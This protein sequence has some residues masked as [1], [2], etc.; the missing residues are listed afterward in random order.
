M[1]HRLNPWGG[2]CHGT[3]Q[4]RLQASKEGG[5]GFLQVVFL[6]EPGELFDVAGDKKAWDHVLFVRP[7]TDNAVRA[8]G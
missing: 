7:F 1:L 8:L 2:V 3:T 5:P 4:G 6:Q